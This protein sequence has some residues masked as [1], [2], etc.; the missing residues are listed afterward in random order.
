[1]LAGSCGYAHWTGFS[2]ARGEDWTREGTFGLNGGGPE[3]SS[4]RRAAQLPHGLITASRM[5][6]HA[7]RLSPPAPKGPTFNGFTGTRVHGTAVQSIASLLPES[8]CL[9]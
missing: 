6:R 2:D 8:S 3:L 5:V 9:R 1:V 4:R 7:G